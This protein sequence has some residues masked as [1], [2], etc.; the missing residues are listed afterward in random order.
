MRHYQLHIPLQTECRRLFLE[1]EVI[2]ARNKGH[3]VR[4][5]KSCSSFDPN[6]TL[7]FPDAHNEKQRQVVMEN[8]NVSHPW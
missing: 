7:N 3:V 1:A 6:V 2:L 4:L 5:R 8:L